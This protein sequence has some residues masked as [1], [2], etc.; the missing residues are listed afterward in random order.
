MALPVHITP[1]PAG[2]SISV[3][4]L[5]Y[6]SLAMIATGMTGEHGCSRLESNDMTGYL[7]TYSRKWERSW[8]A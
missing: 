7:K 1:I 3:W 4:G 8:Y 2:Q 5:K 6:W